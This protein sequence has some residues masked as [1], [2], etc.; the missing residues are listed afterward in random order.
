MATFTVL[1]HAGRNYLS[2]KT[3][4]VHRRRLAPGHYFVT[5]T[6]ADPPGGTQAP[7]RHFAFTIVH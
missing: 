4:F 1:G 6:T 2:L 7:P 5:I 3:L